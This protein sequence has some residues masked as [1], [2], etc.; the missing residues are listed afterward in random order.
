MARVSFPLHSVQIKM[1]VVIEVICSWVKKKGSALPY[2]AF[3]L[4]KLCF[5]PVVLALLDDS[6]NSLNYFRNCL[7]AR[8]CS[9]LQEHDIRNSSSHVNGV[10]LIF[11]FLMWCN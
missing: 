2:P 10:V 11:S 6:C 9:Q 5:C 3:S 7:Y 8:F 1:V 4:N